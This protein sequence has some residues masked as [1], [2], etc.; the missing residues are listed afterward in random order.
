MKEGKEENVWK[1]SFIKL[2]LRTVLQVAA[3]PP[4]KISPGEIGRGKCFCTS[5][6]TSRTTGGDVHASKMPP[7][8]S[9][10]F[11]DSASSWG[12]CCKA[13]WAD[14]RT[15]SSMS[16][17]FL[18]P[19]LPLK[20]CKRRRI[21]SLFRPLTC[22]ENYVKENTRL[23]DCLHSHVSRDHQDKQE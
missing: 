9:Q 11:P 14:L 12:P 4:L 18:N 15:S 1:R 21:S 6:F 8:Q 2:V 16:L 19:M 3:E 23:W 22:L 7:I 10:P 5:G 13:S 17:P 20:S